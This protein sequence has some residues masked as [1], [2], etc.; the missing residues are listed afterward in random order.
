[1]FTSRRNVTFMTSVNWLVRRSSKKMRPCEQVTVMINSIFGALQTKSNQGVEY[2]HGRRI[3]CRTKRCNGD[4]GGYPVLWMLGGAFQKRGSE[5][6]VGRGARRCRWSGL[7]INTPNLSDSNLGSVSGCC[8]R[9]RKAMCL[10]C[11]RGQ[12]FLRNFREF[13]SRG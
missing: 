2:I 3:P 10:Y 13:R 11:R 4:T 5:R 1:V 9:R 12:R 6:E 8:R 7:R